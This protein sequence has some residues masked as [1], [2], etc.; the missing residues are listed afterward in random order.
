MGSRTAGLWSSDAVAR[1]VAAAGGKAIG[2]AIVGAIVS[3]MAWPAASADGGSVPPAV[4]AV[5]TAW[6]LIAAFLVFAMQ[7][8]FVML[9]AGFVQSGESV[10]VVAETIADT[11]ICG[12]AFWAVGF[13]FMFGG[14][15]GLLGTSGF[16]LNGL[17]ATY[18][19]TGVPVPAFWMFQFAF[20][21]TCST[22]ITG[23]L[24]G[25]CTF[26]ANLIIAALVGAIVYP[27]LGHW[28]WGPD[29]WLATLTPVPF[30]DF[31]GST[32]VH[33][34]GGAIALAGSV[35]L[36]PRLGRVFQRD[37]GGPPPPHN[38]VLAACGGLVLWFGWYGFNPGSTLS[39]M[40]VQ[41][42]GRVAL[43]TT[44]AA[45]AAGLTGLFYSYVMQ[46]TWSPA[47][48]V[49]GFLAGLVAITCPCYWVDSTGAFFI[50]TCGALVAGAATNL[51]EHLRV[52]DPVGAAPV[53]LAAGI[54]G[55]LSLG[56][57]ATGHYGTP[58]A[59]GDDVTVTLRGLLY[60]GG[61]EQL[62]AQAIGS[63]SVVVA[64]VAAAAAVMAALR[65]SNLLRVSP[66]VESAGLDRWLHGAGLTADPGRDAI[67]R[68]AT[69][70][71][72]RGVLAGR[73]KNE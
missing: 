41:G 16:F 42:I 30:R 27:I 10:N 47:A 69:S 26:A 68:P 58:T 55:T 53:H 51:L 63:A 25:R 17:P 46:S 72:E 15:T 70:S 5:N 9:E 28:S 50:G 71:P 2:V 35:A 54:W 73:R 14:G 29:G 44:I 23:G 66:E 7:I 11:C 64:S 19:A 4:N 33:S 32:V 31:A 59:T 61:F 45:C 52:D 60:G 20:A 8:G 62:A 22:I 34:V 56:L 57:F 49:N 43:N 36:G 24:L 21:N 13:A 38:V 67:P 39:A 18:G 3:F 12:L 40:D 65:V 37:G 6:T 48:A 1:I